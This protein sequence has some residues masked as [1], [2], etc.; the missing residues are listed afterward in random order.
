MGDVEHSEGATVQLG[1]PMPTG[2]KT[3]S[4]L[5]NEYVVYSLDQVQVRYLVQLVC[6]R[7]TQHKAH[8]SSTQNHNDH[9]IH[10]GSTSRSQRRDQERVALPRFSFL[11]STDA[12]FSS[13]KKIA[14]TK[15]S[16]VPD[17]EEKNL[18]PPNA[19][20]MSLSMNTPENRVAMDQLNRTVPYKRATVQHVLLNGT[21]VPKEWLYYD[22]ASADSDPERLPLLVCVP[23]V[24]TTA[25]S[26]F[27]QLTALPAH[28]IRVVAV[29]P[30]GYKTAEQW[31]HGLE[32]LLTS[33]VRNRPAHFFGVGLGAYL[34]Q[35]FAQM[36]SDRV[37]SAVLCNGYFSTAYM[38]RTAFVRS[39]PLLP[40]F[41]LKRHFLAQL[42]SSATDPLLVDLVELS[43]VMIE[44]MTAG[45]L[46]GQVAMSTAAPDIDDKPLPVERVTVLR[47][48]NVQLLN[49][50]TESEF[51]KVYGDAKTAILKDGGNMPQVAAAEEVNMHLRVHIRNQ[52]QRIS[53]EKAAEEAERE[54]EEAEEAS[55][56]EK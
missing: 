31:S 16:R 45:Q 11:S 43:A 33:V 39:A 47:S 35:R 55:A 1:K 52:E 38:P 22:S 7:P 12:S 21:M 46:A 14:T 6:R 49:D 13:T 40:E 27:R 48:G 2:I 24:A 18:S 32:M 3:S 50:A 28:G 42:N 54:K 17:A 51:N 23:D 20:T 10:R 44:S 4:L 53:E 37:L 19:T 56:G 25:L 36:Y 9:D 41:M 5:Y 15:Q 29:T 30:A 8:T 26:F 34:V